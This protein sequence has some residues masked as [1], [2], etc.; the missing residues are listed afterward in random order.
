MAYSSTM[1]HGRACHP[2]PVL[3]GRA[4]RITLHWSLIFWINLP[5]GIRRPDH[6]PI[7]AL[8]RACRGN[9]R[10]QQARTS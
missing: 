7:A 4:H 10:P 3:G 5:L 8:R 2:R 9:E 1:F 6:E